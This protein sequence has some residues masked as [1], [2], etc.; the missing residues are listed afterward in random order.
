M[1]CWLRFSALWVLQNY[2]D[3]NAT[4]APRIDT[5]DTVARHDAT[6][7]RWGARYTYLELRPPGRSH[8]HSRV[9]TTSQQSGRCR[10]TAAAECE[11]IVPL[12]PTDRGADGSRGLEGSVYAP[13]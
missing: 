11:P 12:N 2:L 7:A 1:I 8:D 6:I 9:F 13:G 4:R 5:L 3:A 10:G